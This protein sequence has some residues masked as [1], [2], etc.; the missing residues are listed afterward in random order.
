MN[1][2][3]IRAWKDE[4]YRDGL[5]PQQ[6]ALVLANPAGAIELTEEE[7]ASVDGAL[8]PLIS[9]LVSLNTVIWASVAWC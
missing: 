6:Q 9:F 2:D 5:T 1:V 3:M 8:T 7:L 4:A